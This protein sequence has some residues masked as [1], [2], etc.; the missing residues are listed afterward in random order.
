MSTTS[1]TTAVTV[2]PSWS[3]RRRHAPVASLLARVRAPWLDRQLAEGAAPWRS[4]AHAERAL[5]LTSS[6][7]RQTLASGLDRL[8]ADAAQPAERYRW[9]PVVRPCREQVDDAL[10]A[11]RALAARLRDREPVAAR[12]M[13]TLRV[14]LTDGAGPCYARSRRDALARAL[15]PVW[16][17]L[18][19]QT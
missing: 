15:S 16:G 5:Q 19:P 12:G 2:R 18:D 10:P 9:T 3:L 4:R 14:L 7:A 1:S 13:A 6:K 8:A 11:I 17:S